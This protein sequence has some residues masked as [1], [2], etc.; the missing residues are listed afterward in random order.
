MDSSSAV[1]HCLVFIAA[2]VGVYTLQWAESILVPLVLAILLT[3]LL[4]PVVNYLQRRHLPNALAVTL[5]T[6]AVAL[7]TLAGLFMVSRQV[8]SLTAELPKYQDHIIAKVR[9]LRGAGAAMSRLAG[10][11]NKVSSELSPMPAT[12]GPDS[13]ATGPASRATTKPVPVEVVPPQGRAV[14]AATGVIAP[15][16]FPITQFGIML[17]YVFFLLLNRDLVGQ[18][19]RWLMSTASVG[20]DGQVADDASRRVG[21]Y[22]RMQLL[23]NGCYAA[24]IFILLWLFGLPNAMLLAV[25]AAILRYVPYVGPIVGLSIPTLLGIAVFDG[26]W[27][28]VGMLGCMVSIEVLTGS[29]FEPLA[30][31]SSTGVS[32]IGVVLATFFWG[33]LWGPVGLVLALPITVWLVIAGRQIPGLHTLSMLL[34][35]EPMDSQNPRR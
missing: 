13:P 18:R 31:G 5:V 2:V 1:R 23:V 6:A 27:R 24:V 7:I 25:I 9:S 14:S 21:R 20:V 22:L 26:W 8:Y 4:A 32:S 11:A 34:S 16:I 10:T 15:L 35:A 28:P 12:G 19:L 3:D 30:Y 29:V 33:W 17:T